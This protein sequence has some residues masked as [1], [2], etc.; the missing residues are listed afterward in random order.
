MVILT[1]ATA[2][3]ALVGFVWPGTVE[4]F[5]TRGNRAWRASNFEAAE[6]SFARALL[7]DPGNSTLMYNRG[8]ARYRLR[9]FD[10]AAED[11]R[12]AAEGGGEGLAGD[13][14]Y[15]LGNALFRANDYEGA[16][17]AYQEALRQNPADMEAKH[18]LELAQR[19][20]EQQ[21]QSQENQQD[22]QREQQDQQQSEQQQQDQ[23]QKQPD[24]QREQERQQQEQQRQEAQQQG[25]QQED[26]ASQARSEQD[27]APQQTAQGREED[28]LTAAEALRLLRA[29]AAEDANVQKIIRHSPR[30]R[31]TAPG[32]K[33]W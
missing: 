30:R 26:Q 13:A 33:D 28:E 3:P 6:R 14:H 7:A 2:L 27:E 9:R 1:I 24:T 8:T 20:K 19:M 15:N 4:F 32:E 17:R 16:I 29:L 23:T 11:F 22:Q 21:Q 18:N 25:Q 10:E 5:T 31:E 12:R